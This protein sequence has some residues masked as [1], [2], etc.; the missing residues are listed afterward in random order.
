MTE[1]VNTHTPEMEARVD[2]LEREMRSIK[3]TMSNILMEQEKV[4][5]RFVSLLTKAMKR[6]DDSERKIEASD[7]RSTSENQE[8]AKDVEQSNIEQSHKMKMSDDRS[9]DDRL[10]FGGVEYSVSKVL[11]KLKSPDRDASWYE[12]VIS[13]KLPPDPSELSPDPPEPPHSDSVVTVPPPEPPD[14]GHRVVSTQ[15]SKTLDGESPRTA[16]GLSMTKSSWTQPTGKQAL[17]KEE[18]R[19][20]K[21][22]V[23]R[24]SVTIAPPPYSFQPSTMLPR[25]GPPPEPP[26][27]ATTMGWTL[28]K[29]PRMEEGNIRISTE[30]LGV[31]QV[32]S[33]VVE[34]IVE[35]IGVEWTIYKLGMILD[36]IGQGQ[37]NVSLVE[38]IFGSWTGLNDIGLF[39]IFGVMGPRCLLNCLLPSVA[40]LFH[41]KVHGLIIMK[42]EICGHD[43]VFFKLGDTYSKLCD[44]DVVVSLLMDTY[45]KLVGLDFA[46][47][48]FKKWEFI[49]VFKVMN[50][51]YQ[52]SRNIT[53]IPSY[54]HKEGTNDTTL[55][56]V[57]CYF[58]VSFF[59]KTFG[60]ISRCVLYREEANHKAKYNN[61]RPCTNLQQVM[62]WGSFMK[63]VEV[64]TSRKLANET[65][66]KGKTTI[67]YSTTKRYPL[68]SYNHH[69]KVLDRTMNGEHSC[70]VFERKSYIGLC[71]KFKLYFGLFGSLAN[72][73]AVSLIHWLIQENSTC[74]KYTLMPT[75]TVAMMMPIPEA[76]HYVLRKQGNLFHKD[77]DMQ[78]RGQ[79]DNNVRFYFMPIAAVYPGW[80]TLNFWVLKIEEGKVNSLYV[81]VMKFILLVTN[82]KY[83]EREVA[84]SLLFVHTEI[85]SME[86][87]ASGFV[88]LLENAI[89]N[90]IVK[91]VVKSNI[92]MSPNDVYRWSGIKE[93]LPNITMWNS[94]INDFAQQGMCVEALK[95]FR[96]MRFLVH[97][98]A[99]I[100]LS[101]FIACAD[102]L[103]LPNGKE[104]NGCSLRSLVDRNHLFSPALIEMLRQFWNTVMG[105]LRRMNHMALTICNYCWSDLLIFHGL[106]NFVFDRGKVM[107]KQISTLRTRLF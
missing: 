4:H 50:T 30:L 39:L 72:E 27:L 46:L 51:N 18:V 17:L 14:N 86:R 92:I 41:N 35:K 55:L 36:H 13:T 6:S 71:L 34:K 44:H 59:S 97:L 100:F 54:M 75:V 78:L 96:N 93:M 63:L 12:D 83:R 85:S 53:I 11:P 57:L 20:Q 65:M 106:F 104:V 82:G 38:E 79:V 73:S 84:S 1:P 99:R 56:C 61:F 68:P 24:L 60:A 7:N 62:V 95:Y 25:R 33:I 80:Q 40:K 37:L 3:L 10:N 52:F 8:T 26:D 81:K 102:L 88:N 32:R 16:I 49:G 94:L 69:G 45:L 64:I 89:A 47:E 42:L 9:S 101:W 23:M 21:I 28:T 74:W 103:V 48:V 22:Q 5:A 58:F 66:R 31:D 19:L 2:A 107:W 15:Q 87:I 43:V 29:S 77:E 70:V 98:C 90:V 67:F 91:L 105:T 76:L